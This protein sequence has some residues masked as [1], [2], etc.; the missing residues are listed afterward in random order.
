MHRLGAV[1]Q[2][3]VSFVAFHDG[4]E[5]DTTSKSVG[6]RPVGKTS[7]PPRIVQRFARCIPK[8]TV[9]RTSQRACNGNHV[10]HQAV[11]KKRAPGCPRTKKPNKFRTIA[12]VSP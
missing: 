6:R 8:P 4:N 10:A 11:S 1:L 3:Q 9:A 12:I 5:C 2:K 7:E